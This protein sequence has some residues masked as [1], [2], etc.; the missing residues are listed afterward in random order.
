MLVGE[1]AAA[2]FWARVN[3]NPGQGPDGDCWEWTGAMFED[4]YP[5]HVMIERKKY[6]A[7]HVALILDG[8]PMPEPGL[9]A[10]HSCDNAACVRPSHLRW[11]TEVDNRK[12]AIAR[13][14]GHG[15]TFNEEEIRTIR[16]SR[17][18]HVDLARQYGVSS[19]CIFNIRK[20][21]TYK[22]VY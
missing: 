21:V 20:R 3:K 12:D 17:A 11:G 16:A 4:G 1:K 8:R 9:W 6:R 22:H 19:P 7:S 13:W 2:R 15:R 5:K 10:L 14:K 18:R